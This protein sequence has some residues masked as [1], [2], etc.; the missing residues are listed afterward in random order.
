MRVRIRPRRKKN[1][2]MRKIDEEA[3]TGRERDKPSEDIGQIERASQTDI[4]RHNHDKII[5]NQT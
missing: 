1:R 4:N 5:G 3:E 2:H